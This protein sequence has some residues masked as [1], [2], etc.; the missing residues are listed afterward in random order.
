MPVVITTFK[1]ETFFIQQ[2]YDVQINY[3]SDLALRHPT[4]GTD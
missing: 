1:N 3:L 2:T 4:L